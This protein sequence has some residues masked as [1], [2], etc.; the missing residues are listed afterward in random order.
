MRLKRII[1]VFFWVLLGVSIGYY[2]HYKSNEWASVM[3]HHY[4]YG[5][6]L[7]EMPEFYGK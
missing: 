2:W 3:L 1:V 7:R 5:H 6:E 4:F